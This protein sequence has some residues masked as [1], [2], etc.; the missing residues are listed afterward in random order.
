[1]SHYGINI[2]LLKLKN[3]AVIAITSKKTG[4]EKK[5]LI[6]PIEENDLYLSENGAYLGLNAF[7]S[8]GL[9]DGKTHLL[10]QN[11]TKEVREK[12]TDDERKNMP[13]LGDAKPIVRNQP[14][15]VNA[16]EYTPDNDKSVLIDDLPF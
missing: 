5:C 3:T 12:M 15:A 4:V 14:D 6:I 8:S 7:E 1:M 10:K 2:N 16:E 13:V 9:R 11:H